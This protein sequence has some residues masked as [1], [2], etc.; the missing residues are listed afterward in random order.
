MAQIVEFSAYKD[1][2]N[3]QPTRVFETS[4]K[5]STTDYEKAKRRAAAKER[6]RKKILR[7]KIGF[8]A[9]GCL[10]AGVSSK[11]IKS[12]GD[13][14]ERSDI[15]R[16]IST[17]FDSTIIKPNVILTDDHKG[18]FYDYSGFADGIDKFTDP[19]MKRAAIYYLSDYI[20]SSPEGSMSKTNMMGTV[21]DK[22]D[23][24][25]HDTFSEYVTSLGYKNIDDYRD[26]EGI[27]LEDI[28]DLRLAEEKVTEK[29]SELS[30]MVG[31][32]KTIN[33]DTLKGKGV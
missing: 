9:L 7:A 6:M 25:K 20:Y 12:F 32:S 26:N 8:F 17:E 31:D 1:N 13:R 23:D 18:Y 5:E 19:A 33:N 15:R 28:V 29:K 4:K 2:D 21:I 14:L 27:V 3:L 16:E 10:A 22:L 24:S 11:A 30:K